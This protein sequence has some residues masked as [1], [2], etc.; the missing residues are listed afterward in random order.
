MLVKSIMV[1]VFM[2]LAGLGFLVSLTVHLASVVGMSLFPRE[3]WF[4]HVGIFVVWPPA[5]LCSQALAK[6]FPQKDVWRAALRGCPK[7]MQYALYAL[8]AYVLLNFALFLGTTAEDSRSSAAMIRGFSGH[9]LIFYYA[10][11]AIL[12]SYLQVQKQDPARRCTNGHVVALSAKYC[13]ECGSPVG[14]VLAGKS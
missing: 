10:A 12:Y 9:L 13:P 1:A 4:L 5:V 7:P 3:P 6:E 14:D 11:F 8:F 2:A